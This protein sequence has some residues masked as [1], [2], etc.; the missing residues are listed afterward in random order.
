[1]LI[2]LIISL[3]LLIKTILISRLHLKCGYKEYQIRFLP[4]L[5]IFFDQE[6]RLMKF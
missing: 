5:M 1:M 2:M 4:P 3:L 6:S